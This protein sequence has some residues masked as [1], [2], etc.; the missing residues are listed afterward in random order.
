MKNEIIRVVPL[1]DSVS[2]YDCDHCGTDVPDGNGYY[3]LNEFGETDDRVC[4]ECFDKFRARKTVAKTTDEQKTDA[5]KVYDTAR[6]LSVEILKS[7]G[8]IYD[9][10]LLAIKKEEQNET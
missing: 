2:E 8:E 3:P 7:A 6:Q 1:G 4:R 9:K 10:T 5:W